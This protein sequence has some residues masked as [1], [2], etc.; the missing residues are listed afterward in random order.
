M[1]I[2]A[3]MQPLLE[4]HD[5]DF[6]IPAKESSKEAVR[7]WHYTTTQDVPPIDAAAPKCAELREAASAPAAERRALRQQR[8]RE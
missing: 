8:S 5:I 3:R 1:L 4:K 7:F 2:D 6:F